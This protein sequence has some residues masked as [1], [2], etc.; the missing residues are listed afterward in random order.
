M[1]KLLF[2]GDLMCE[3][4]RIIEGNTQDGYDFDYIFQNEKTYLSNCDYLVGNLESPFAGEEAGY[5]DVNV[6]YVFNAPVEYAKA[7]QAAGFHLVSTANNHCM[8]RGID[9]LYKTIGNLDDI[10]LSHIGTYK[11]LEDRNEVFIKNV[12]GV[13]VGFISYTYGINTFVHK[14]SLKD[15][16]RFAVNMFQSEETMEGAV[17]LLRDDDVPGQVYG[18]Y[19]IPNDI[20]D[21][22]IKPLLTQMTNDIYRTKACGAEFIVFLLHSGGQY[23]P[24]PDS[25]TLR[26]ADVI[27]NA[28]ADVI[29]GNHPHVL[30]PAKIVNGC[31]IA[32]SLGNFIFTPNPEKR[33]YDIRAEYSILLGIEIKK[34]R[35]VKYGHITFSVHKTVSEN[36]KSFVMPVFDLY[37][38]ATND[39]ERKQIEIDNAFCVNKFL[40]KPLN[41]PVEMCDFYVYQ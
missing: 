25:L 33:G 29:I 21:M 28:G 26:I 27:R 13:N 14:T 37:S 39:T 34:N 12:N 22:K 38:N 5:A 6:K 20:Y 19:D 10:K 3:A 1:A 35:N 17:D 11:N 24:W 31:F 36:G 2:T 8:D 30:H 40:N 16:E 41:E 23:N 4:L 9:G 32:Y 7:V 15:G 18:L